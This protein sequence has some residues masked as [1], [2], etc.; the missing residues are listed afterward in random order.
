MLNNILGYATTSSHMHA[1]KLAQS[2]NI[3]SNITIYTNTLHTC[4]KTQSYI[5]TKK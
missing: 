3:K 5:K 4:I 2:S 1:T